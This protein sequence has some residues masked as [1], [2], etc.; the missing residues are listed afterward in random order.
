MNL[1]GKTVLVTGSSRGIGAATARLAK[2]C[3][4]E[5]IVHGCLFSQGLMDLADELGGT[6]IAFD[7]AD[8]K[9]VANKIGALG[10]IDVLVNNA[11]IN[12][13][14]T[15][16][17]LTNDDWQE[18][19]NVNLFGVINVSREVIHGMLGRKSG[20]IVNIASIKGLTHV[21]GKSSYAVSK[22]G[23][24]QLT[25]RM[26]EE[27]APEGIRINAVAPGF[28]LTEMTQTTLNKEGSAGKTTLRDQIK[29]IPM[30]R[31]ASPEEIAET[32]IFLASD[33]ASYITG[34]CLAVDGG[35]SIV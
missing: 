25:A 30:R 8:A 29:K 32:V 26:A 14:K 5:V 10:Q 34:Q 12:P 2:Q 15:F 21:A 13:S 11:G 33:K 4:A 22:A 23:V 31:M 16:F 18:I 20:A 6:A 35:L 28:T 7:V 19:L 1:T 3:G 27:F 9:A 17:Q 24:I